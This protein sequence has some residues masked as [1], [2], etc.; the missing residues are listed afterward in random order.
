M[1]I[2]QREAALQQDMDAF[3][4]HLN[5]PGG[6]LLRDQAMSILSSPQLKEDMQ[7]R[8]KIDSDLMT[9]LSIIDKGGVDS[10]NN[11]P[12]LELTRRGATQDFYADGSSVENSSG[13][14]IYR[15][16]ND[17]VVKYEKNGYSIAKHDDNG[18]WY[19]HNDE[20]NTEHAYIRVDNPAELQNLFGDEKPDGS[21]NLTD[22][23]VE[24]TTP[25]I[26]DY[27]GQPTLK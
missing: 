17:Q 7:A 24:D 9:G 16:S 12:A 2:E 13:L 1:S 25:G 18:N 26:Y 8:L 27:A 19:Y 20:P 5:N 4:P 23:V 6:Q 14:K 3:V 15:N 11:K 10:A 21:V 22:G